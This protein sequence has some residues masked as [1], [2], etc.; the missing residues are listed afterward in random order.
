MRSPLRAALLLGGALSG[1]L[2]AGGCSKDEAGTVSAEA[3][4]YAYECDAPEAANGRFAT[5]ESF[6]AILD[7]ESAGAFVPNEAAAPKLTAPT[8]GTLSATTPPLFTF[9]VALARATPRWRRLLGSLW[10]VSTAE[11]HEGHCPAVSGENYLLRLRRPGEAGSV[12]TALLSVPSFTPDAAVWRARVGGRIGQTL[13][14]V[15]VR[16][17]FSRGDV[18]DGPFVSAPIAFSVAE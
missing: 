4:E 18:T 6:R 10:P 3:D 14:L 9:D 2:L 13:E 17:G 5:G 16:A 1:A 15:L 12:Y 8:G 11:A 7:K